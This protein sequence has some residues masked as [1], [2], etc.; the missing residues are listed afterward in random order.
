MA[1][2]EA[3]EL[4]DVVAF[5]LAHI[6]GEEQTCR[7]LLGMTDGVKLLGYAIEVA[8]EVAAEAMPGG[9]VQL[10]QMFVS[11]LSRRRESL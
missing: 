6:R 7:E 2:V 11:W 4:A 5:L 8:I 1:E 3:V 9:R 10:E